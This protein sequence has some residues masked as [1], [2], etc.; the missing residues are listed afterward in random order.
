[1]K[2]SQ[3]VFAAALA[4]GGLTTQPFTASAHDTSV[5]SGTMHIIMPWARATP[6]G[7]KVGAGYMVIHNEGKADDRLISATS[8]I[9]V[10]TEIHEM[11]MDQ[12]V[13]KMNEVTG[14]LKVK[15]DEKV[16]L[17]PGGYHIMFIDL[18]KPLKQD[19][20]FKGTLVFEKAGKID[21]EYH[22]Q[23]IGATMPAG[24]AH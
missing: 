13:M 15:P 5:K 22:V 6:A 1:M 23:A 18:K 7:A 9:S 19:D 11:K 4:L 3:L 20:H 16:S 8:D 10:R 12:G 24:H 21:I 14:G 2:I 17:K